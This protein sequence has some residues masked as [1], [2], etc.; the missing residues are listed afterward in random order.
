MSVN[1]CFTRTNTWP[2]LIDA[3]LTNLTVQTENSEHNI[4]EV[5]NQKYSIHGGSLLVVLGYVLLNLKFGIQ[6]EPP[7]PCIKFG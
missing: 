6:E 1:S 4:S 5:E 7:L 3:G 2:S